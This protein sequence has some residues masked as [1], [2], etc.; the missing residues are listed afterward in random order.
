MWLPFSIPLRRFLA[1]NGADG[2]ISGKLAVS[3]AQSERLHLEHFFPLLK[4]FERSIRSR[5]I[6]HSADSPSSNSKASPPPKPNSPAPPDAH[7]P[8]TPSPLLLL[9]PPLPPSSYCFP[10][11][12]PNP[13][14]PPYSLYS[15]SLF[16]PL[17][18]SSCTVGEYGR[19]L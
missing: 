8:T 9:H 12:P 2:R 10:S 18:A 11:P 15:S 14:H 7:D 4:S 5:S 16:P 19:R 6:I 13:Q 17:D 3:S 1:S